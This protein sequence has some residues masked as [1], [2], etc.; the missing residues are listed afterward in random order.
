MFN[1]FIKIID[2]P[3]RS[4]SRVFLQLDNIFFSSSI[5]IICTHRCLPVCGCRP[6][7]F[8]K[9]A[10]SLYALRFVG[11]YWH[12]NR[13]IIACNAQ[14]SFLKSIL[15]LFQWHRVITIHLFF[16]SQHSSYPIALKNLYPLSACQHTFWK[17][18]MFLLK[19][20][21]L[22]NITPQSSSW[23][24]KLMIR[25]WDGYWN[26]FLYGIKM[27]NL[28]WLINFNKMVIYSWFTVNT[29]A[30]KKNWLFVNSDM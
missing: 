18:L 28:F 19:Y 25:F 7:P 4:L 22:S 1:G 9:S 5:C 11:C 24:W 29:F 2:S 15:A 6:D 20:S 10:I 3:T 12:S 17:I 30:H 21:A 13:E 16:Y 27:P 26:D 8:L 14:L 23:L